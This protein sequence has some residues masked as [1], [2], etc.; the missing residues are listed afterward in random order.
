MGK[1]CKP[2]CRCRKHNR[3]RASRGRRMYGKGWKEAFRK[4]FHIGKKL[5]ALHGKVKKGKFI[6]RGLHLA[7]RASL[8]LGKK[9]MHQK[10][11]GMHMSAKQLGYGAYPAG[12]PRG[13]WMMRRG[14]T[15]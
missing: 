4:G 6:S 12:Q 7:S 1:R 11:Y 14:Y 10:L 8:A 9:G 2:G 5:H 13:A 15:R 3:S